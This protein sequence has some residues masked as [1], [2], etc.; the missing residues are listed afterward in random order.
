M[1]SRQRYSE[2]SEEQRFKSRARAYANIYQKRGHIEPE[3][4]DYC[5]ELAQKHHPDYSKPLL[6]QWLC[7]KCHQAFHAIERVARQ[8]EFSSHCAELLRTLSAKSG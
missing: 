7:K 6:V 5:G 2:L 8:A 4:C 1:K 3:L